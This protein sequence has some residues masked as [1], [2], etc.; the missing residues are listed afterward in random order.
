MSNK[1]QDTHQE[2]KQRFT[3][4]FGA[5]ENALNGQ[6]ELPFHKIRRKAME[7]LAYTDF[8]TLRNEDWKYTSVN[9]ILQPR[10]KLSEGLKIDR[11]AI[12]PFRF[13]PDQTS[14]I[15][16]VNG[17]FMPDLSDLMDNQ[18]G[19]TIL[20]L[21]EAILMESWNDLIQTEL[22]REALE[23]RDAFIQLNTSFAK[24][25]I[26]IH[27]EQGVQ[28]ERLLQIIYLS[29]GE[30]VAV[31]AA[32]VQMVVLEKDSRLS[33]ME[34]HHTINSSADN[35]VFTT[36][37]SRNIVKENARLSHYKLQLISD[38]FF[39]VHNTNTTQ[40]RDSVYTSFTV[41]LGGRIVRNNLKAIHMGS[42]LVSNLYG[43]FLGSGEQHIDNQT[44]IDH[45]VP[46]C[47]SNEWYKGILEGKARGVFNG[48]VF[49]RQ[50]AQKTNAF[51]QNNT[52]VLS[53]QARMDTKPQLEIF[54][55]DVRCSHGATIG[56]LD[57][58]AL[59]YLRS[60]GLTREQATGI[61]Q[62]AFLQEVTQFI[63]D[64][65]IRL[66]FEDKITEKFS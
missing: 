65:S 36:C 32:P 43:I 30:D 19:L 22:N 45:A 53:E 11:E 34:N 51:Q 26:F 5:Y 1:V 59:F 56:Q 14:C 41:D 6:K 52:L 28:S 10:Y 39:L 60:R 48:K 46:Y 61:L 3:A 50:D 63:Q 54:A 23:S 13:A 49:V 42:N 55:D 37:L 24:S 47:E 40:Y 33:I 38:D 20:S 16:F 25:G 29:T 17:I 4:L 8:P 21:E 2:A 7:S 62:M 31:L 44:L 58:E 66:F 64:E 12:R 35:P 9:R 18:S 27:V 15:V 57:E